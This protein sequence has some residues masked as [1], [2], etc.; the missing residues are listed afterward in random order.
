MARARGWEIHKVYRDVEKGGNPRRIDLNELM[1][2]G[3]TG[4]FDVVAF[5]AWDRVT[6]GGIK[7]AMEI[8]EGW[9]RWG[10]AWESLQEPFLSSA[11]DSSTSELILAIV[12]WAAKQERLRISER[13]K[14]AI[15][16]RRALGIHIGR[17]KGAKD[18]RPRVRRWRRRP[19][20]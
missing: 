19:A 8:M 17:P 3:R 12:A 20:F 7:A 1:H 9:R 15:A 11:A 6:R 10:L 2:E 14:A 5:W 4:K 18:R 13:T 16:R